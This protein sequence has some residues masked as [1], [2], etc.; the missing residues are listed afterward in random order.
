M[1]MRAGIYEVITKFNDFFPLAGHFAKLFQDS[2]RL[3]NSNL[4]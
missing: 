2:K 4:L 1:Y 3:E